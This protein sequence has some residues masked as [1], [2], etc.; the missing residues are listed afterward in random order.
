MAEPTLLLEGWPAQQVLLALEAGGVALWT[1]NADTDRFSMDARAFGLWAVPT[2]ETVTFEESSGRIHP[3][4]R[5]RIRAGFRAT[6]S[7]HSTYEID[8]RIMID[9]EV[10]WISARGQRSDAGI[11]GRTMLGMFLDVTGRKQVEEA[12][13]LLAGEMS[14]L[15]KNLLGDRLSWKQQLHFAAAT[16]MQTIRNPS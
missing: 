4:D 8:F 15:V 11:V 16:Q 6:R 9:K 1:W 2:S 14:P 10:R 7:I 3:A 13:E 5:D 12:K